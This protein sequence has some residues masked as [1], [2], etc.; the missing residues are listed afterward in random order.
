M[1]NIV[2]LFDGQFASGASGATNT[3]VG[4]DLPWSGD[5][6]LVA[7]TMV[8]SGTLWT[9]AKLWATHEWSN[10]GAGSYITLGNVTSL[11]NITAL[12][13]YGGFI[14]ANFGARLRVNLNLGVSSG[15]GSGSAYVKIVAFGRPF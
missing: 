12:G 14:T 9:N 6:K 4:M 11:D 2:T 1:L 3:F 10:D 7:L 5:V 8:V 15:T 13:T